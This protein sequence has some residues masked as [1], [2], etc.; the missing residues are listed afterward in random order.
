MSRPA[1]RAWFTLA[2]FFSAG[3]FPTMLYAV[4]IGQWG[5]NLIW[6]SIYG[7][8]WCLATNFWSALGPQWVMA[9][10]VLYGLLMVPILY[11]F[12]GW[13]WAALDGSGRKWA[14]GLLLLS[15]SIMLPGDVMLRLWNYVHV[16]DLQTHFATGY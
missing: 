2:T 6:G 13:L 15:L 11:W 7:V 16:P 10:G 14:F 12:S 4:T 5:S 3:I 8:G 1:F 9:I